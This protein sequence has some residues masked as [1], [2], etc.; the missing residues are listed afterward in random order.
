MIGFKDFVQNF[1]DG[2]PELKDIG[3]EGLGILGEG[4]KIVGGVA[5]KGAAATAKVAG[6]IAADGAKYAMGSGG[7]KLTESNANTLH[8][9]TDWTRLGI[10]RCTKHSN[11]K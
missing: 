8:G 5:L 9:Y 1:K 7:L 11:K 2:L 4:A 10:R 3:K 6:S